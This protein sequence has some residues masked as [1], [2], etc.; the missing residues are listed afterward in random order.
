M[1]AELLLEIIS[2][3]PA[4]PIPNKIRKPLPPKYVER[5]ITLRTLSQLCRSLR[6]ALLPALWERIEVWTTSNLYNFKDMATDLIAQLETVTIREPSLAS[7]VKYVMHDI[8][9]LSLQSF[10]SI[11]NVLITSHSIDRVLCELARCMAL[12][13]NLHTVQ[14]V[15]HHHWIH[16]PGRSGET[17]ISKLLEDAFAGYRFPS[18]RRVVFSPWES[19]L[20]PCF[21]EVRRVYMTFF[22]EPSAWEYQHECGILSGAKQLRLYCPKVQIFEWDAERFR[23]WDIGKSKRH[24]R[25]HDGTTS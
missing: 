9:N 5:T 1:P 13:E 3:I 7:Y 4:A 23:P 21:P 17:T 11:V 25:F 18:V 22:S 15:F 24:L 12:M 2:Y 8:L 10:Y 19:V 6:N 14:I 20:L 16:I